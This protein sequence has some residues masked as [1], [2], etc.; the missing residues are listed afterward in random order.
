MEPSKTKRLDRATDYVKLLQLTSGA[1]AAGLG[2]VS[3]LGK[4]T[5]NRGHQAAPQPSAGQ[6]VVDFP[7]ARHS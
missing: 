6:S 1:L 5:A 4:I 2:A 3:F 7:A